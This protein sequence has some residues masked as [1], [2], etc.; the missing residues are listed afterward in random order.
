MKCFQV[1]A[2]FVCIAV[3]AGGL[4]I[5]APVG[6]ASA[7]EINRDIDRV[8][9]KLYARIPSSKMLGEKAKGILVFPSI[10]KGGFIV[11]GQYG[12]GALRVGG[13]TVGYYSSVA[14]SYGCR[15][16]FRISGMHCS[17]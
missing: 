9:P 3:I 14:V 5:P 15:L 6:A 12:E 16:V 1:I 4:V 8:L 13:R 11:G 17:S 2:V 7:K 10:T